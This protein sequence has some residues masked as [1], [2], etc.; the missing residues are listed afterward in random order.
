VEEKNIKEVTESTHA[1]ESYSRAHFSDREPRKIRQN[2]L[3]RG[4]PGAGEF[5]CDRREKLA[6][7]RARRLKI[8]I[9]GTTWEEEVAGRLG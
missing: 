6:E 1:G 5:I 7:S 4:V 2:F 8:A 3:H 9:F